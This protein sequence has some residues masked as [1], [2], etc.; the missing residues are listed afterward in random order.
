[1]SFSPIING[2]KANIFIENNYEQVFST[3]PKVKLSYDKETYVG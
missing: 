1:M 3:I 2:H